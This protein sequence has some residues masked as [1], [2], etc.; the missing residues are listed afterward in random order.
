[1]SISLRWLWIFLALFQCLCLIF[2]TAD[3][4]DRDQT[5]L[6]CD[7]L[8]G[9]TVIITGH[10]GRDAGHVEG[11]LEWQ[12]ETSGRERTCHLDVQ[13]DE[14][15]GAYR[16]KVNL[17]YCTPQCSP[18]LRLQSLL[19][20]GLLPLDA[21]IDLE[22]QE[23]GEFHVPI[24]Q[25]TDCR[26]S[27]NTRSIADKREWA[28]DDMQWLKRAASDEWEQMHDTSPFGYN[29]K[30]DAHTMNWLRKR[31]PEFPW[32]QK[33]PTWNAAGAN[34]LKKR[35]WNKANA[36]WLK[37][38]WGNDADLGWLKRGWSSGD[39][40]W[41]KRAE[42]YNELDMPE[43]RW[44]H[45][46]IMDWLKKRSVDDVYGG[47]RLDKRAWENAHTEW[48]KR[49]TYGGHVH[50]IVKRDTSEQELSSDKVTKRDVD[51]DDT[52]LAKKNWGA[53]GMSWIKRHQG[54][55]NKRNWGAS[56]MSWIKRDPSE[57]KRNWGASGMSWIKRND[58]DDDDKVDGYVDDNDDEKRNWGAS[59]MSWIKRNP[60]HEKRNWGASGMSWIKR[61]EIPDKKTWGASGMSWIKRQDTEDKKRNWGDSGM[62]WIKKDDGN[63]DIDSFR[64]PTDEN[65]E[66]KRNWGAS[67]MSW[68]KRHDVDLDKKNW[69]ASGMSWI[70]RREGEA[71]KKNWGA[72]GMSWI[73]RQD[74]RVDK[75]NW[76]ASGMSWIKRDGPMPDKKNWGA[77]GMSWIKRDLGE[78]NKR[79]WGASGMSWIKRVPEERG[80]KN[81]GASGM[82]W[83]KRGVHE[84]DKKNWGASGMSWIKRDAKNSLQDKSD[85]P[86]AWK[87]LKEVI[88]S[89]VVPPL[90]VRSWARES[91]WLKRSDRFE[92][93][94][95]GKKLTTNEKLD[96]STKIH[97]SAN[98]DRQANK[99]NNQQMA[100][101]P[102]G[103]PALPAV[104][105]PLSDGHSSSKAH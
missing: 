33:K 7:A 55:V 27:R 39:V 87:T 50:D 94:A 56:G 70:K 36:E 26:S 41:L 24:W 30:F 97:T 86:H 83:I 21:L 35:A 40:Q 32:L 101:S 31:A 11:R 15:T 69:G 23:G 73:K 43:K 81:W 1:M 46:E 79:N 78:D 44:D 88:D 34:W 103:V 60:D 9:P 3:E 14:A 92:R 52:G 10:I 96:Q 61:D 12:D 42:P 100:S 68:I 19:Y 38:S 20:C 102:A 4:G 104:A 58:D 18:K 53:S 54:E 65:H 93:Q 84:Q 63:D 77:S 91:D 8:L 16:V 89:K 37:R 99:E 59:G 28:G 2:A 90:H 29:K 76:G 57:E 49:D 80:K 66:A 64:D 45:G 85:V 47:D 71:D 25:Y 105:T 95:T 6:N 98:T 62:S 67:G 48:I 5:V 82:S 22:G 51:D 17:P 13:S 75:K 72:S 74:P